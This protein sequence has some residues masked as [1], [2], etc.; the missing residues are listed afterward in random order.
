LGG[1]KNISHNDTKTQ[2]RLAFLIPAGDA[3]HAFLERRA[4]DVHQ[5]A[6]WQIQQ[7]KIGNHLFA[8]ERRK[9]LNRFTRSAACVQKHIRPKSFGEFDTI[10]S[11]RNRPL[12][13]DQEPFSGQLIRQNRFIN[14]FEQTWSQVAVQAESTIHSNGRQRFRFRTY[15]GLSLCL[16]VFV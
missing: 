4:S 14:G 12:A 15:P 13:F 6:D 3:A 2:R 10:I 1:N 8:M 11:Y 9:P 5:E 16:C 7:P